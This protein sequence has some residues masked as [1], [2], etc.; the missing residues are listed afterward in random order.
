MYVCMYCLLL[1]LL[2]CYVKMLIELQDKVVIL[3]EAH[4]M[5]DCAREAASLT[6]TSQELT[7]VANEIEE[8]RECTH[9]YM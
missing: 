2:C 6:I 1:C 8:I 9:T 7:E 4:N 3:D 5:E